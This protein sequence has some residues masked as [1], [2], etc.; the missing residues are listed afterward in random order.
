LAGVLVLWTEA[1][2]G[3]Q[4][5]KADLATAWGCS[6]EEVVAPASL[7]I[8]PEGFPQDTLRAFDRCSNE[9]I[10]RYYTARLEFDP[11]L[12]AALTWA[13]GQQHPSTPDVN[14][15]PDGAWIFNIR[16]GGCSAAGFVTAFMNAYMPVWGW[17][18]VRSPDVDGD[19]VVRPNDRDY[20]EDHMSTADFCADLDG[21]GLVDAADLAIVDATMGDICSQLVAVDDRP[22]EAARDPQTGA[23]RSSGLLP[24][25]AAFNLRVTPN[26]ARHEAA[27]RVEVSRAARVSLAVLDAGGRCI[28]DL[29]THSLP[30]GGSAVLWDAKDGSGRAAAAGV[31]FVVARSGTESTRRSVILVP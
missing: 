6:R 26:P 23:D 31:Y 8:G 27:F 10:H 25:S 19:C 22:P 9:F 3:E 2:G 18:G 15:T 14:P 5:L 30:D 4:A 13:D 17:S 12:N 7:L 20:V 16:G 29:G 1:S 11:A 21:S 24:S 28:R